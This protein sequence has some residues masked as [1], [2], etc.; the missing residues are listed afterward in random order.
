MKRD[1]LIKKGWKGQSPPIHSMQKLKKF[2]NNFELW[3]KNEKAS[4][5]NIK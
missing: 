2:K 1:D 5:V 4:Q 3:E